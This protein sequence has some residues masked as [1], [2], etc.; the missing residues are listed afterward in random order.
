MFFLAFVFFGVVRNSFLGHST[1]DHTAAQ[2]SRSGGGLSGARGDGCRLQPRRRSGA[3]ITALLRRRCA[4]GPAHAGDIR[5]SCQRR[6]TGDVGVMVAL[7]V[8]KL[9]HGGT[10]A[11]PARLLTPCWCDDAAAC[12]QTLRY[13]HEM[14]SSMA[15]T[16]APALASLALA[17]PLTVPD[18]CDEVRRDRVPRVPA[19][20]ACPP[21]FPS[22]RPHVCAHART[23][24]NCRRKKR[25]LTLLCG[26]QD[27]DDCPMV[28]HPLHA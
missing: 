5:D 27:T 16:A 26:V 4:C 28:V 24:R 3:E 17:P 13:Y 9:G 10:R 7:R 11:P 20:H 15:P 2:C 8:R 6:C 18:D 25:F 12:W 19:C 23:S 21:P 1:S 22:A 14:R